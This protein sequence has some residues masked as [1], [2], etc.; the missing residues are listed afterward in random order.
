MAALLSVLATCAF[1]L[2][3]VGATDSIIAQG[4]SGSSGLTVDL[5]YGIYQGYE[6]AGLNIWKGYVVVVLKQLS[7]ATPTNKPHPSGS[8]MR[9][10]PLAIFVGEH[11]LHLQGTGAQLSQRRPWVPNVLR[12]FPQYRVF[13]S[14]REMRTAYI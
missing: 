12:R 3:G 11:R 2:T 9:R 6:N 1:A 13:R 5:S 10:L 7:L 4:G 8:D 14:S